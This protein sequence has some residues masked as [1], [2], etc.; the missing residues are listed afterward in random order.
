MRPAKAGN[1]WLSNQA[2]NLAPWGGVAALGQ[3]HAHFQFLHGDGRQIQ[4]YGIHTVGPLRRIFIGPAKAN[5]AQLG[6]LVGIK[7]E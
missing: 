7:K 1:P 5:L 2:R 4:V 3:Q 6:N